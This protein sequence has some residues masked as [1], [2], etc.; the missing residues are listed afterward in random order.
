MKKNN[1]LWIA[2][3]LFLLLSLASCNNT[4]PSTP[5]TAGVKG[6]PVLSDVLTVG[7]ANPG[8][9]A[10]DTTGLVVGTKAHNFTLKD[11]YG[12]EVRLS[13]LLAEKPV[14]MIF[15]SFSCSNCRSHLIASEEVYA[16]YKDAFNFI[17]VCTVEAY[18]VG[19][20]CPYDPKGEP[21]IIDSSY[22]ESG[23]DGIP[24]LQPKTYE[25]RLEQATAFV[26]T[27]HISIPMLVDEMENPVWCTFGPA[28]NIAYFIDQDGTVLLKQ[29]Y[30]IPDEM[31]E[32]LDKY[33]V[34]EHRPASP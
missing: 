7:C 32:A 5:A 20:A 22:S 30:Y 26:N 11:I 13:K 6:E 31:T 19:A 1:V 14:V 3:S 18:P 21:F 12:N 25:Q 33:L 17:M 4:T 29:P 28:S 24:I 27:L 23:V 9:F 15:G 2:I 8:A 34:E 10:N 16:K